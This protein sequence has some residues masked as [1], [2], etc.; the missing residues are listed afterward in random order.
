MFNNTLFKGFC[1]PIA[2]QLPFRV[3]QMELT[4][5]WY[6]PRTQLLILNH[7]LVELDLIFH[8]LWPLVTSNIYDPVNF[9]VI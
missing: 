5:V 3:H 9:S 8:S 4:L 1:S 6:N 7:I 2:T